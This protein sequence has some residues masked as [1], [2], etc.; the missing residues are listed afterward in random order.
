MPGD[1]PSTAAMHITLPCILFTVWSTQQMYGHHHIPR[2]KS[3]FG[4]HFHVAQSC[5][6]C[7]A[8]AL[9][10]VDQGLLANVHNY[11]TVNPEKLGP[12]AER[13][14]RFVQ[15]AVDRSIVDLLNPQVEKA[16]NIACIAT[17][18]L[19]L[20]VIHSTT[21]CKEVSAQCRAPL[22]CTT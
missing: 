8:A 4:D 20:K 7:F 6:S 11:V 3:G 1:S 16:V 21:H 10:G 13:C 12:L 22:H 17:Q 18:E 19:I 14:K 15:M 5:A 2:L 9:P